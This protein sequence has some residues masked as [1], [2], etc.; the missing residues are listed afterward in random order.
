LVLGAAAL[1][2]VLLAG[3]RVPGGQA[4][5]GADVS[6]TVNRTGELD[7]A[8]HGRLLHVRDLLPGGFA[9]AR[10]VA[11]NTTGTTLG[12]RVRA[13]ADGADLDERLA[14]R[15]VA[16]R[17]PLF[18]GALGRLRVRSRRR[19]VLTAGAS[20]ALVVRVWL[21]PRTRAYRARGADLS[22]EL[23]SDAAS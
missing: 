2:V 3:W 4:T 17:R 16:R 1:A 8:P 23:L 10:F 14:L 15:V 22:L 18:S 20:A 6:V 7:V 9:E 21:P 12:V 11:T 19:L 13:R 5:P